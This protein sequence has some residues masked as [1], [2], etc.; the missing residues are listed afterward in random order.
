[1]SILHDNSSQPSKDHTRDA[2]VSELAYSIV[3][4]DRDMWGEDVQYVP[5]QHDIVV[6]NESGN[7]V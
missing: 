2:L 1:M 6:T 3:R 4:L 7:E 5:V